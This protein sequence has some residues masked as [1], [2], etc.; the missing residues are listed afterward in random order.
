M[1]T[2]IAS[3]TQ[4]RYLMRRAA[5][6]DSRFRRNYLSL[7]AGVGLVALLSLAPIAAALA[8]TAPNLGSE[9]TYGVT[10]STFTNS[11][12]GTRTIINGDVCYTTPP[13]TPPVTITGATV[14]PCP[15][16]I[17]TDQNSAL[18]VLNSQL[19]TCTLLP[20]GPL[21]GTFTPGCYYSV[22]AINITASTTVTLNGAGVYIFMST[23]GA[24]NTGANS[25]VVL[26]NGACANDVFWT[27]VGATT[28]GATSTFV[29]SI[30]DNA[31]ITI[32]HFTT[33]IGRALDPAT[34]VT[35]D[36]DTI[37]VPTCTPFGSSAAI[38]IPT[39]SEWAMAMLAALLAI[40][41]FAALRRHAR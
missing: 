21:T 26:T 16:V 11:N 29:G 38:R 2:Q 27:A 39:L 8:A 19:T 34:T 18:A 5:Q 1:N 25:V 41:G 6:A 36:A 4:S 9:R 7:L 20:S 31:G 37:T 35:T 15:P 40:A 33:L 22:G 14:T 12:T 32:G 17:T 28:L 13:T 24:I 23:G 10:S 30:L 3:T